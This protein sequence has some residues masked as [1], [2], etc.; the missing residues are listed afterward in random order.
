MTSRL[1]YDARNLD[2]ATI[3]VIEPLLD[4]E[5]LEKAAEVRQHIKAMRE[6]KAPGETNED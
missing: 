5:L 2:K 3:D 6:P 1:I 4:W